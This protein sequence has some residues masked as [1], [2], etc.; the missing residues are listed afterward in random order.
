MLL[1]QCRMNLLLRIRNKIVKEFG[2]FLARYYKSCLTQSILTVITILR[3]NIEN[4][5]F[6]QKDN[7]EQKYLE[8]LGYLNFRTVFDVG[9][10]IGEW[11]LMAHRIWPES[12]IH[13]FEIL[14]KH[15]D[16]FL[17]NTTGSNTVLLNKFGLSDSEGLINVHLNDRG[18][19]GDAQATIYPQYVIESERDYYNSVCECLVRRGDDYV[20]EQCILKIDL[21]KIDVEGHEL[22]VIEGFGDFIASVR[23]IQFEF[24]VYN[25]TSKDLLCDF[26]RYLEKYDFI[27]GRLYPHFVN[28]FSYDYF[29]ENLTG[30]NYL[31]VNKNDGELIS[32]LSGF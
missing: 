10:L 5:N 9:A 2:K 23:C 27:I 11:A 21:L 7:G 3:N 6:K 4:V 18:V 28:F 13:A 16:I 12:T 25:I 17:A 31:A 14:P 30:G 29:K 26:F 32:L 19:K 15:W 8:K 20:H 24:G 22:K 1:I